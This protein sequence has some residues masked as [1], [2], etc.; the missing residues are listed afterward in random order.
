MDADGGG[1]GLQVIASF[2]NRD[3]PPAAVKLGEL[4]QPKGDP[5]EILLG[6]RQAAEGIAVVGIE[7]R[8]DDDEIGREDIEGR[9]DHR[10]HGL[11][12]PVAAVA[13]DTAEIAEEALDL[14]DVEYR[15]LPVLLDP[16]EAM[17][18]GQTMIIHPDTGARVGTHA[19]RAK[20]QPHRRIVP[21]LCPAG[22]RSA[23]MAAS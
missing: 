5:G 9:Q 8:R 2:Q 19:A 13:A 22:C 7:A 10:R 17:K 16:E 20:S 11:S 18:D 12:E 14:I 23:G 6:E 15:E 4:H 3:N 1:K 21:S